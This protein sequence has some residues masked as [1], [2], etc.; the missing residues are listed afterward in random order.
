MNRKFIFFFLALAALSYSLQALAN[1]D[2]PYQPKIVFITKSHDFGVAARQEV[3][4]YTFPYSNAGKTDFV[5]EKKSAD[6][7]C[8]V[9]I[10]PAAHTAPDGQGAVKVTINTGKQTG[11]ITKSV[12]IK[13]NEP[14]NPQIKLVITGLVQKAL[15]VFPKSVYFAD[16]VKGDT[17]SKTIKLMQLDQ[18]PLHL[19]RIETNT[20]FL[21]AHFTQ[22]KNRN[23]YLITIKLRSA[24]APMGTFV[25]LITLVTNSRKHRKI[26]IPVMGEIIDRATSQARLIKKLTGSL[27]F[28]ANLD[29]NWDVFFWKDFKEQPIRLT[30]TPYDE[31]LPT[32][33]ID[34]QK[35]VYSTTEGRLYI[36]DLS[37]QETEPLLIEGFAGK[38]DNCSF[39]PNGQQL[40]CTY[41]APQQ[42]DKTVLAVIDIKKK[43][44]RVVPEPLVSSSQSP[45]NCPEPEQADKTVLAG[46]AIEKKERHLVPDPFS[47][48]QS[49]PSLDKKTARL[50]LDQFG[51]QF[52]PA[53][54]PQ[55]TQIAYAYAHCSSAC[56]R[57][58]QELWL[59]DIERHE[60]V[61]F[62]LT[63]AHCRSPSWSPQGKNLAFSADINGNFDI[64]QINLRTKALTRETKFTGLDE[65]PTFGS[66]GKYLAFISNRSGKRA[67]W[68]KE[69]ASAR[70]FELEPFEKDKIDI[71]NIIWK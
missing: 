36:V 68:I 34:K 55:G 26:D 19:E 3:I 4:T 51:P 54:S 46:V 31:K 7:G 47:P 11:R 66:Q 67:I 28:L 64:W 56:G 29:G 25:E 61:Q 10:F 15:A 41:L 30:Q 9:E 1:E 60:A 63:N 32:F 17:V 38:W 44:G 45:Q 21:S 69:L 43:E 39:S 20:P 14:E 18:I 65:S 62:T 33:S 71:K 52:F 24:T 8:D 27:S 49:P 40:V 22:H 70:L 6:C 48:F 5:V 42:E 12:L 13:T 58:I 2:E 16:V 57:I 35:L 59:T 23:E 53:W 50:I 37:S